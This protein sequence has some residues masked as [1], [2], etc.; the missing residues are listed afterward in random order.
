MPCGS[1]PSGPPSSAATRRSRA[2]V[3]VGA[4]VA[5]HYRE[6]TRDRLQRKAR[7]LESER[8]A[9]CPIGRRAP[10]RTAKTSHLRVL[11]S[12]SL[13]HASPRTSSTRD[14]RVR[15]GASARTRGSAGHCAMPSVGK[16]SVA[17]SRTT[18]C[19]RCVPRC[20]SPKV[21]SA[22]FGVLDIGMVCVCVDS[23]RA[24]RIPLFGHLWATSHVFGDV[25][26]LSVCACLPRVRADF[27][28]GR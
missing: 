12:A 3:V 27:G 6:S 16:R 19:G 18:G 24:T 22:C 17:L 8:G 1:L 21:Y 20:A 23:R 9:M 28:R 26:W 10:S 11:Q 5:A 25:P 14:A 2:C 4:G 15:L 13:G 7:S